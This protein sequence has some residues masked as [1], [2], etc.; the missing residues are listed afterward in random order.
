MIKGKVTTQGQIKQDTKVKPN[1]YAETKS[2]IENQKHKSKKKREEEEHE[3]DAVEAFDQEGF[4]IIPKSVQ[5]SAEDEEILKQFSVQN[6]E[7]TK[8]IAQ[9]INELTE[10]KKQ[11][12][13][14]ENIL[15][16]P[17]VKIVYTDIANLLKTYRSGK[18]ARAF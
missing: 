8:Q 17:K 15:N 3:D 14:K 18:L 12:S 5:V 10:Q 11:Q 13:Y 6:T 4:F 1:K 16:N 9:N 2:K 7:F